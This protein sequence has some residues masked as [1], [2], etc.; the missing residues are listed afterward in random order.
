MDAAW[1]FDASGEPLMHRY[2]QHVFLRQSG[3]ME[4]AFVQRGNRLAWFILFDSTYGTYAD[5]QH[6]NLAAFNDLR[7]MLSKWWQAGLARQQPRNALP[8]G[9]SG[10]VETRIIPKLDDGPF[11]VTSAWWGDTQEIEAIAFSS[12]HLLGWTKLRNML[13]AQL[14]FAIGVPQSPAAQAEVPASAGKPTK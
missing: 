8:G 5:G 9:S 3:W 7:L 14:R 13:Y 2:P 4:Q 6:G 10:A 12:P 11:I 1:D